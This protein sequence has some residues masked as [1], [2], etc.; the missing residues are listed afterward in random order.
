M[1]DERGRSVD[2]LFAKKR[3]V[4]FRVHRVCTLTR[5]ELATGQRSQHFLSMLS[6]SRSLC[7]HCAQALHADALVAVGTSRRAFSVSCAVQK[8]KP[9]QP[10]P[11]PPP[12]WTPAAGTGSQKDG[13]SQRRVAKPLDEL[14]ASTSGTPVTKPG[15]P[16]TKR[17]R[18]V[19][20]DRLQEQQVPEAGLGAS[21]RNSQTSRAQSNNRLWHETKDA[22]SRFVPPAQTKSGSKAEQLRKKHGVKQP[23]YSPSDQQHDIKP[24]RDTTKDTFK[25]L[26]PQ[27]P[28]RDQLPHSNRPKSLAQERA[29]PSS[30]GRSTFRDD[31][32]QSKRPSEPQLPLRDRLQLHLPQWAKEPQTRNRFML[33]G[34]SGHYARLLLDNFIANAPKTPGGWFPKQEDSKW[35]MQRAEWESRTEP[36]RALDGALTRR[37]LA[38]I[39]ASPPENVKTPASTSASS[40]T[41]SPPATSSP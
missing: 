15:P 38:W 23:L 10:L 40:D 21:S 30:S 37:F 16:E 19:S 29:R 14:Q 31:H 11:P 34:F 24:P 20:L 28:Y 13:P 33:M 27:R 5:Q 4:K 26:L 35:Q 17:R 7:A 41:S 12:A 36:Q 9:S 32:K 39:F 22:G 18:A 3:T 1:G 8:Q 2:H 25:T 6:T